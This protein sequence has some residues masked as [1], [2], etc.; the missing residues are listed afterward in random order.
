MTA[1]SPAHAGQG[2]AGVPRVPGSAK[3]DPILV[4][5]GVTRQFGGVL[6]VDVAHLEVQRHAITALIGPNGAGKTTFFNLMTGFDK[7]NH[8][9][10]S[11]EGRTLAGTPAAQVARRGMVR[12][13]QL[14]KALSRMTVLDNMRLGAREQPGEN[15]FVSLVR[16]AWR[17]RESE[18]TDKAMTLLERFRLEEKAQDFA[19]S[20][21]G[22]QRKLLEMARALMSDPVMVMLDEPM[23]GVNPALTQ[24]LLGHIT[25]LRDDGMTVLFVEHDMHMV[26]HISDWV[27]VMAQGEIVA[28][29]PPAE[30]MGDRAV[31]DAYLGAHHD[32]DLGDDALLEEDSR[33]TREA[34]AEADVG[35]GEDR[36]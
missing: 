21:S 22:G 26:R 35:P 33:I 10:W 20:L 15:L 31:V 9:T 30:V 14:T 2:F 5:D 17:S 12:T 4:A 32:T 7:A 24:S 11:F 36:S 6:A 27:V 13:F 1:E 23:A 25:A 3:P 18:I 16:P 19:G 28:E 34:E 8:G 29:G